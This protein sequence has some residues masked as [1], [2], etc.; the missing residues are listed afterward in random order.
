MLKGETRPSQLKD[1]PKPQDPPQKPQGMTPE[2]AEVW[3][4]VLAAIADTRHIGQ[5]HADTFRT[6]CEV[7]AR[8]FAHVDPMS[9]EWRDLANSHRQLARELCLTPAT[10]ASL[11][12]VTASERKL[13]R[14]LA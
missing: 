5:A 11:V 7:T 14:F 13:D 6:Y 4:R 10:G 3:D 2:A 8:L 9:R 12:K 1:A